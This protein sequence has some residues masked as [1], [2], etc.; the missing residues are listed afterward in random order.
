[1]IQDGKNK[2]IDFLQAGFQLK[3]FSF[4]QQTFGQTFYVRSHNALGIWRML[5]ISSIHRCFLHLSSRHLSRLHRLF[6][7]IPYNIPQ[8]LT[9]FLHQMLIQ[10]CTLCLP[11]R[12]KF[13]IQMTGKCRFFK[14]L[15]WVCLNPSSKECKLF[16]NDLYLLPK[17]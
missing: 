17:Q 10:V 11:H 1:M 6:L 13:C 9:C 16:L 4:L 14:R 8:Q 7:L 3:S 5:L 12:Y 2:H 15:F